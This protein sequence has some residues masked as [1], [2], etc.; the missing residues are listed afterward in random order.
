MNNNLNGHRSQF[1][2][3]VENVAD[4]VNVAD[5]GL[6]A[7]VGHHLAVARVQGHFNLECKRFFLITLRALE[8]VWLT[9]LLLVRSRMLHVRGQAD[10]GSSMLVR[11]WM[12]AVCPLHKA[13]G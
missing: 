5:V 1:R 7:L 13:I 9:L 3:S 6:L 10:F 2:L 8:F 11:I 12:S 4:G